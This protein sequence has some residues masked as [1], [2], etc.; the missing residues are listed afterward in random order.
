MKM[1]DQ[2]EDRQFHIKKRRSKA[3]A[4]NVSEILQLTEII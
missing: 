3:A 2:N 4:L 1:V